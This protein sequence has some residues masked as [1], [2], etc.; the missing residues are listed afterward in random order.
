MKQTFSVLTLFEVSSGVK[1]SLSIINP[2]KLCVDFRL[3][4]VKGG[5]FMDDVT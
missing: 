4:L 5:D 3:A 2:I 1:L